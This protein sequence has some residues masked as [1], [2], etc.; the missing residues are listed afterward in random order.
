MFALPSPII[1][2]KWPVLQYHYLFIN[3]ERKN[4][5][6]STRER[7]ISLV[8]WL[9]SSC[10]LS[11][12][13]GIAY[14]AFRTFFMSQA[15]GVDLIMCISIVAETG[16]VGECPV[17]LRSEPCSDIRI[18]LRIIPKLWTLLL[19]NNIRSDSPRGI[20]EDRSDLPRVDV[21]ITYCGESLDVLMD[22]VRAAVAQNYPRLLF[23]IVILDDSASS[24]VSA[25]IAQFE[26]EN[27]GHVK[28]YY[29]TRRATIRTHSKAANL[30][31][32][33]RFLPQLDGD[34]AEYIAVLDVD[35][36]PEPHWLE[37]VMAHISNDHEVG[38]ANPM[39]N[40]F[41][42]PSNDRL[43]QNDSFRVVHLI[44]VLQDL[45]CES[46]CTGTGFVVR[47]EALDQV[48][49][50]PTESLTEDMLLA[51][52]L[53][54]KGWKVCYVPGQ[55]Q[56][57]LGP[58]SFSAMI[59]QRQRLTLGHL[60]DALYTCVEHAHQ[61]S[62][63]I[64]MRTAFWPISQIASAFIWIL[65]MVLLPIMLLSG[66]PLL[67]PDHIRTLYALAFLDFVSQSSYEVCASSILDFQ[68][69]FLGSNPALWTS[70]FVLGA[71]IRSHILP[72]ILG[73]SMLR[74]QPSGKLSQHSRAETQARR[75]KQSCLKLIVW[76]CGAW[77]HLI[78][79]MACFAAPILKTTKL[80]SVLHSN[81]VRS[82]SVKIAQSMMWPPLF[83][84]WLAIIQS[85]WMP[86]GYGLSPPPYI[87]REKFLHAVKSKGAVYPSVETKR[88]ASERAPQ[89]PFYLL[90]TYH[91]L[92]FYLVLGYV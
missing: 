12:T 60:D 1:V 57:G 74:F 40:F 31:H 65:N 43:G 52:Q 63:G 78:V 8:P 4:H 80:F 79:F 73:G 87:P 10:W 49:G 36:I 81:D 85:A 46:S 33:L 16:V 62:L 29:T 92:A 64:R 26:N 89:A 91:V 39:Q 2:I 86:I 11:M 75:Q 50:F 69:S 54:A 20:V 84:L 58:D 25:S 67:P 61:Y 83:S 55:L 35:M 68:S 66:R 44:L 34:R 45:A 9:R 5:T 24:E 13:S 15:E 3:M 19:T 23:R 82:I 28:I 88:K 76:D 47:R 48:G 77:L 14:L 18:V 21:F 30:N 32:G 53:K 41:N 6:A 71:V 37:S 56:W 22:T 38:L 17:H 59:T 90:A 70:P 51:I 27:D 42:L 72:K 7:R